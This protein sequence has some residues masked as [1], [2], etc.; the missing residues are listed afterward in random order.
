M[1]VCC[2]T[3]FQ[4]L[5]WLLPL[6]AHIP[7]VSFMLMKLLMGEWCTNLPDDLEVR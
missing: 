3:G 2:V 6:H 4:A 7:A 1:D 5:Q